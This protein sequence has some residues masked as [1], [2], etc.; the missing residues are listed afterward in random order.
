MFAFSSLSPFLFYPNNSLSII[1]FLLL[2]QFGKEKSFSLVSIHCHPDFSSSPLFPLLPHDGDIS[3]SRLCF[4]GVELHRLG[5][6]SPESMGKSLKPSVCFPTHQMETNNAYLIELLWR[7]NL[8]VCV[9][10]ERMARHG[11]C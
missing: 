10:T 2:S 7:L 4:Q 8:R 5:Q 9:S 1:S 3:L 11:T 6:N